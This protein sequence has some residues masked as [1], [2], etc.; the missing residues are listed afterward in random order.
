MIDSYLIVVGG[1]TANTTR[2]I[3]M[4]KR[5]K[6]YQESVKLIEK[7]KFYELDEAIKLV[8]QAAKAKF[9]NEEKKLH[10]L[11]IGKSILI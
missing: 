9:E 11:E 7:N 8:K 3:Q 1:F 6:A 2:R 4:P 5:G 10:L